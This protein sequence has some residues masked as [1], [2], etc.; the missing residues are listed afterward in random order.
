[1]RHSGKPAAAELVYAGEAGLF[2]FELTAIGE[3]D[4]ESTYRLLID[5]RAL[6]QK[7]NTPVADKRVTMVHR[8]GPITLKTGACIVSSLPAQPTAESPSAAARLGPVAAGARSL[9]CLRW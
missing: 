3:E 9:S 1:V 2:D 8:W 4:G 5:G 6:E 7:R